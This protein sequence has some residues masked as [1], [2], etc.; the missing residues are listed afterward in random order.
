MGGDLDFGGTIFTSISNDNRVHHILIEE[1]V[2]IYIMRERERDTES[3]RLIC[4]SEFSFQLRWFG[5]GGGEG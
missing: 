2:Y 1:Y 5:V 3:H 4:F